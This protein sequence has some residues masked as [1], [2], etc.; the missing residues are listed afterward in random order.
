[1]P[2][3]H[4]VWPD[5]TNW[6]IT[7]CCEFIFGADDIEGLTTQEIGERVHSLIPRLRHVASWWVSWESFQQKHSPTIC[8]TLED[9]EAWVDR[10]Q[11]RLARRELARQRSPQIRKEIR[12]NYDRYFMTIGRRDGFHCQ[13]CH[14]T[15]DLTIDHV[16]AV[17]NGGTNDL[18][19]LQLLCGSCNSTKNDKQ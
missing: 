15:R 2:S 17:I 11:D 12:D 7:H 14:A 5:G 6:I 16:V 4:Y 13:H 18:D 8:P 1:M 19:Q 9:L 10:E 3:M